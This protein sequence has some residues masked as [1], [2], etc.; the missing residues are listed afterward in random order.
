[1]EK[2]ETIL[3]ILAFIS[4]MTALKCYSNHAKLKFQNKIKFH[5]CKYNDITGCEG[6]CCGYCSK[7]SE[8]NYCCSGNCDKC[9]AHRVEYIGR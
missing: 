5:T 6:M 3:Y 2:V 1:M 4:F 9:V 7:K 8:C